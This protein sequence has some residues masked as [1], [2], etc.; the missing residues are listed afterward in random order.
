LRI[1]KRVHSQRLW[2]TSQSIPVVA[3]TAAAVAMVR[4][5]ADHYIKPLSGHT[6]RV[7]AAGL[8]KQMKLD[9]KEKLLG[10]VNE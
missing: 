2:T 1:G 8:W 9:T 4:V 3:I 7:I 5:A 10:I 6:M